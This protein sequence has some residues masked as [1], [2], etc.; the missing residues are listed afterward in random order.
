MDG[1]S[2]E[3]PLHILRPRDPKPAWLKVRAPGS[4]TYLRLKQL[5][6]QV[7]AYV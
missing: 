2:V 5:Y 6:W 3:A 1:M 7:K 4:E